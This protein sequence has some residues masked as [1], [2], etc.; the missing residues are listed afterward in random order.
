MSRKVAVTRFA[1]AAVTSSVRKLPCLTS[2]AESSR[3]GGGGGVGVSTGGVGVR[4]RLVPVAVGDALS[5]SGV[6]ALLPPRQALD[7]R[8]ASVSRNRA[9]VSLMSASRFGFT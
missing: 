5:S 3:V 2:P 4:E 1:W 9:R 6:L 7:V 8:A